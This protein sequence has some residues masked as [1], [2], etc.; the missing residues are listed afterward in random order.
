VIII[1]TRR[2]DSRRIVVRTWGIRRV[3]A[4]WIIIRAIRIAHIFIRMG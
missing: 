2:I 3:Y 4:V 1:G